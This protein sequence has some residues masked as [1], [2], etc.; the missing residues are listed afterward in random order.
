MSALSKKHFP[1]KAQFIHVEGYLD[2]DTYGSYLN[3][4]KKCISQ[5]NSAHNTESSYIQFTYKYNRSNA[6][7]STMVPVGLM[8]KILNI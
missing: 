3:G 7:F 4:D 1:L 5:H 6:I 8:A 2:K